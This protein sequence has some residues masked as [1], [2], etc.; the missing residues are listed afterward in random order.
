[1]DPTRPLLGKAAL[2]TGA[3]QGIGRGIVIELARRGA[4]V[5]VH[6]AHSSPDRTMFGAQEF[7]T[8][9]AAVGGKLQDPKVCADVVA[10]A[11]ELLGGLDVLVNNAG[12]TRERLPEETS[13][14]DL[15]EMLGV[16]LRGYFVCTQAALPLL[17]R[18][19]GS[20]VNI[21]SIQAHGALARHAAYAASKG[22]INAMTRALAI[23]L[24]N[25][26]VRVNA[27]AP[28]VIEVPRYF[29]RPGYESALYADAIPLGRVG[30]PEDVAP[31]VAFL[32]SEAAGF[33]TCQVIYVDGGTTAQLGFHRPPLS[34]A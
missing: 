32:A 27:V 23:D 11:A 6:T 18:N 30:K 31:L 16:N 2:V 20:V 5:A 25:D 24:A 10:E 3:G 12:V 1:M 28:G 34:D 19:R 13:L 22:G 9:L 21:S 33:I 17:R 29:D 4:D 7:G 26:G 8:R 15:E 14:D